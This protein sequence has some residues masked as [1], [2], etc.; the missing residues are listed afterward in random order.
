MRKS[1]NFLITA[2]FTVLIIACSTVPIT[3]RKQVA[4]LPNDMMLG[5]GIES[6]NEFLSQNQPLPD[7]DE[8][9]VAVRNVG[10]RIAGGVEQFLT[11]HKLGDKIKDYSWTFNVV[12]DPT[13]NAWCMPGGLIVFYTGI[14]PVAESEEGV[15]TIMGHEIAH[16]I[17]Q[18]GNERMTQ[19]LAIYLGAVSLDYA[20]NN[21]PEETRD[22]FLTAYG[23]GSTLGTLAYSRKHEYE[24]DKLGMVF[25]AMAGYDPVA[26][27]DFWARMAQI[28]GEKPPEL[29]ST[30]PDDESRIA[31]LQE[32]LPEARKYY[33][34]GGGGSGGSGTAP[35]STGEQKKKSGSVNFY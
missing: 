21:K 5:M 32:F 34:E 4:L 14:L 10:N 16:A 15:A 26:A 2:I 20:L 25:M 33:V 8:R 7:S 24:A 35:G 19:Q 1:V 27:V 9:V 22:I 28:G 23:V 30:H 29:L 11:D 31:A 18:H 12:D 6:Y 17:A 13:I 3:Q